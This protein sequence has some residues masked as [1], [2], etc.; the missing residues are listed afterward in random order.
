MERLGIA[1]DHDTDHRKENPSSCALRG[2]FVVADQTPMLNNPSESSLDNPALGKDVE[3]GFR[4][5][6]FDDLYFGRG[7]L[8]RNPVGELRAA[9]SPVG[10]DLAKSLSAKN[11]LKKF[12][13]P[14]SF[15]HI[16][17]RDGH[18]QEHPQ[19]V[20]ANKSLATLDFL[21]RIVTHRSAMPIGT[22]ALAVD[23][24]RAGVVA[25]AIQSSHQ[26]A[27]T[28]IDGHQYARARPRSKVVIDGFPCRKIF[29]QQAP[30]TPAF[31]H[32]QHR[33]EHTPQTGSRPTQTPCLGK[34]GRKDMPLK[35]RYAG[36]I[37]SDFHRSKTAARKGSEPAC[38]S[39]STPFQLATFI[40]RQ[41]LRLGGQADIYDQ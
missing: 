18:S 28:G 6:S 30:G 10:P 16:G 2:S 21:S 12:L 5:D 32:K 24:P 36:W 7:S 9:E 37:L 34:H 25:S 23:D 15:G 13:G 41:P 4:R 17:R 38:F 35:V 26:F 22:N 40:F 27:Q 39:M 33:I 14:G 19:S 3:S 8:T 29:R 31:E 20:D 1:I 11:R